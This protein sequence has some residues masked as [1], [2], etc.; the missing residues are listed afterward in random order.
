MHKSLPVSF[1]PSISQLIYFVIQLITQKHIHV[2][3]YRY[4][5]IMF[6]HRN[7][8]WKSHSFENN[9]P[10]LSSSL[11]QLSAFP[12][13]WR[14]RPSLCWDGTDKFTAK[15]KEA[16]RISKSTFSGWLKNPFN[17]LNH[18]EVLPKHQ[19]GR[20]SIKSEYSH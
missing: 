1:L 5:I 15:E 2:Y 11:Q 19:Q 16:A 8:K 9:W 18:A 13:N 7:N 14:C 12:G 6:R 10:Y 4:Y 17:K 3:V 20:D